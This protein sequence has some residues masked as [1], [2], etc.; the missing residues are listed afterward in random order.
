[1]DWTKKKKKNTREKITKGENEHLNKFI[2]WILK[3][4]NST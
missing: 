3:K 4:E 2:C 1:M